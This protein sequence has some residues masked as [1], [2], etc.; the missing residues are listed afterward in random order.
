MVEGG[1]RPGAAE[2]IAKQH[3]DWTMN[4][5]V[6][7]L[8]LVLLAASLAV[9]HPTVSNPYLVPAEGQ[10]FLFHDNPGVVIYN[11]GHVKDPDWQ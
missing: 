4:R 9:G 7:I 6:M 11:E 1:A 10:G 3:W 2:D 8:C 5:T